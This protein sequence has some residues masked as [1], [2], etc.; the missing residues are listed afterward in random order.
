MHF[1]LSGGINN[2]AYL[3]GK[4]IKKQVSLMLMLIFTVFCCQSDPA[5]KKKELNAELSLTTCKTAL[6]WHPKEE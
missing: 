2:G 3:I 4:L 5:F 6:F 1:V